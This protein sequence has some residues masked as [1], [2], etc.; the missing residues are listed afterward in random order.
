MK[1]SSKSLE[2]ARFCP[3]S[4]SSTKPKL[5]NLAISATTQKIKNVFDFF[6]Y[7]DL[8]NNWS[9]FGNT[10]SQGVV[11]ACLPL[12]NTS[13]TYL[14]FCRCPF[15]DVCCLLSA[16]R[17]KLHDLPVVGLGT[18]IEVRNGCLSGKGGMPNVA[19]TILY[20]TNRAIKH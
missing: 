19:L 15:A 12:A 10:K 5:E 3:T 17:P 8:I 9:C 2:R 11:T 6:R 4:P 18:G 1:V 16:M 7:Y 20:F 13:F 14:S